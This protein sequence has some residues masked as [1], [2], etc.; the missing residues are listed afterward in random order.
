MRLYTPTSPAHQR[1]KLEGLR[2][3]HIQL[4]TKASL[5]VHARPPAQTLPARHN[6]L[7]PAQCLRLLRLVE[8]HG[9]RCRRKVREVPRGLDVCKELARR[10]PRFEDED[11]QCRRGGSEAPGEQT[12]RCAAWT[13]TSVSE[14]MMRVQRATCRLR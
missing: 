8:P 3:S 7:A 9:R 6:E 13:R 10:G 2:V 14:A 4:P 12:A 1:R 5:T 11:G